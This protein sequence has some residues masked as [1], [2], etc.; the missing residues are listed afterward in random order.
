MP[1]LRLI[2]TVALG[3]AIAVAQSPPKLLRSLS[4]PSGKVVG[5]KFVFDETRMRFTYPQDRELVVYF[6]WDAE[7]GDHALTA[8]WKGPDGR[9]VTITQDAR[10]QTSSRELN[11]YWRFTLAPGM[12]NGVWTAEIRENGAK[13][14]EQSFEVITPEQ[15]QPAPAAAVPAQPATPTLE[16]IYR[17]VMLSLVWLHKLDVSGRRTDTATGFVIS[18]DH[19]ATAFQA[20]DSAGG[21]EIEFPGARV[22]RTNEIWSTN[23]LQ[24]WAIVKV[25]T[26]TAPA[27]ERDESTASFI[28]E[29]L[30]VLNVENNS[31]RAIGGVDISGRENIPVFGP[32]MQMSPAP[33]SEAVGGP[34]LTPSGKV[35][36][37]LGGSL[38][39]GARIE[40]RGMSLSV[41]IWNA[42]NSA[43]FATPLSTVSRTDPA[44]PLTLNQL[45]ENGTL[46]PPIQPSLNFTYGGT[47][48]EM[49]KDVNAPMP[50]DVSEF[51][52]RDPMVWVYSYWRKKDKDN[53]GELAAKVY[54]SQN[55]VV[56]NLP[57]KKASL[58]ET[59][60]RFAFSFPPTTLERGF[61]RVDLLWQGRAVWRT[62][63]RILD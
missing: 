36:A 45:T 44:S 54:D 8:Q 56:V 28:G 60:T 6:E 19:I 52:R 48:R 9:V 30:I 26:G 40:R 49:P 18:Q 10:V 31:V 15:A 61:Y 57:P 14:G 59:A 7:P 46:T 24:D 34:L 12:S 37:V 3:L 29:R 21:L 51:S 13:I 20:I 11:S 25:P 58:S 17:K 38:F 5:S 43:G 47:T 50:G 39:P 2:S 4:G 27:L 55:R 1:V 41:S 62:F 42:L 33:S 63:F 53:K 23:R 16:E 32:R 35:V 22:E